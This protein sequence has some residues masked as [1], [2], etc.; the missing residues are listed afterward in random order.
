MRIP[1]GRSLNELLGFKDLTLGSNNTSSFWSSE[2]ETA[3][4][5]ENRA[6]LNVAILIGFDD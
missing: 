5:M 2:I 4:A 6:A 1:F 3:G